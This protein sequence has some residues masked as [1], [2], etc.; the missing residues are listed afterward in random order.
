VLR[1]HGDPRQLTNQVRD[2][3]RQLDPDHVIDGIAPLD[4]ELLQASS[5]SRVRTWLVG[6]FALAALVL[7]AIGLYGVLASDVAQRR[8]EIGVR[9][10]LGANPARLGWMVVRHG[11]T[12][13]AIGLAAGLVAALGLGRVLANL[14]Y[15]VGP[16][17]AVTFLSS[18]VVL[19]LVALVASYVPARRAARLDPVVA[20]RQE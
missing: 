5:E 7:S 1:G 16:T 15:G 11:M 20:L 17:D 6:L 2:R 18:G 9:L 14:L 19:A 4:S 10:A 12:V 8:Q 3:L 13:T